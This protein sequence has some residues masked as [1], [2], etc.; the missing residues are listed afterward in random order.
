MPMITSVVVNSISRTASAV[1]ITL[2][3]MRPANSSGVER[4][5]LAEHQPVE[6]PAQA[7]REVDGQRLVLD[8][9][10]Q[11]RPPPMLATSTP[12]APSAPGRARSTGARAD[13]C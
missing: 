8:D 2:V 10:L 9:G 4:H 1:C 6:V 13:R 12:S 3:V 5:A 11:R 7:Q